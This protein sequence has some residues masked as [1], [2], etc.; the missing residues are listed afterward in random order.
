MEAFMSH[1]E[2]SINNQN[3]SSVLTISASSALATLEIANAQRLRRWSTVT[4]LESNIN[5]KAITLSTL[6]QML[7]YGKQDITLNKPY[8]LQYDYEQNGD[9]KE[10]CNTY[11]DQDY[12]ISVPGPE[13]HTTKYLFRG[14]REYHENC[15]PTLYRE[16]AFKNPS[17]ENLVDLTF[18]LCRR[19]M[20]EDMIF[21]AF[22]KN[23]YFNYICNSLGHPYGLQPTSISQHYGYKT[24]VLDLTS[25]LDVALFFAMFKPIDDKGHFECPQAGGEAYLY[26]TDYQ[27]LLA[28]T[29]DPKIKNLFIPNPIG[30]QPLLRSASQRGFG[31]SMLQSEDFNSYINTKCFKFSYT[32]QEAQE[33]FNKFKGGATL[34]HHD[35][36]VEEACDKINSNNIFTLGQFREA[37]SIVGSIVP[38]KMSAQFIQ[39]LSQSMIVNDLL[40]ILFMA[41]LKFVGD[42]YQVIFYNFIKQFPLS[43]RT[44]MSVDKFGMSR[45]MTCTL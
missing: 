12:L 21:C 19:F 29:N 17:L 24:E 41:K 11:Q 20:F 45:T 38:E 28:K 36:Q 37:C 22:H 26:V 32:L 13:L 35:L 34:F 1:I 3:N 40:A 27:L 31:L 42:N 4:D 33:I 30:L 7:K 10:L 23:V 25:S 2:N 14:Q 5:E 43:S 15:V 6:K 16:K 8:H 39:G 18:K 44:M 9:F